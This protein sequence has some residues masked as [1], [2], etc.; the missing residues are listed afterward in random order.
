MSAIWSS[1]AYPSSSTRK[2]TL[3]SLSR[4]PGPRIGRLVRAYCRLPQPSAIGGT[5]PLHAFLNLNE[6]INRALTMALELKLEAFIKASRRTLNIGTDETQLAA[7][8]EALDVASPKREEGQD[9]RG[10]RIDRRA[11]N[12]KSHALGLRR[13]GM[14]PRH[15]TALPCKRGLDATYRFAAIGM[16]S[17]ATTYWD[18][19]GSDSLRRMSVDWDSGRGSS[20]GGAPSCP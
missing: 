16:R 6:K 12:S 11:P 8:C 15:T 1:A 17:S 7:P 20:E 14:A 10:A 19:I 9:A 2:E 18:E 5:E 4:I 13:P 3:P